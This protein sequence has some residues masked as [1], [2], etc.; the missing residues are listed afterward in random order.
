MERRKKGRGKKVEGWNGRTAECQVKAERQGM[1][2]TGRES[3]KN[4][5][6]GGEGRNE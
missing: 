4:K 6:R 1:G 2:K 3:E 5:E